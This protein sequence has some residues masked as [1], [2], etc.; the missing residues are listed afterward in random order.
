MK[1]FAERLT[2]ARKMRGHTQES[3][4]NAIGVSRG[5]TNNL[6]LGRTDNPQMIVV[7]AICNELN[8]RKEW[9]LHGTGEMESISGSR[10][11]LDELYNVC[12]ELS[13]SE[14][15]YLIA[16]VRLM[17]KHNLL[18]VERDTPERQG[19]QALTDML[20]D[21]ESRKTA[22]PPGAGREPEYEK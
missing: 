8:I 21:V 15:Q 12:S 1:T 9:L 18:A 20:R 10:K 7:N 6:E 16:Q 2:Y 22:K 4:A 13:E 3:L 17:Q 14:I 11:S 5:V 19:T